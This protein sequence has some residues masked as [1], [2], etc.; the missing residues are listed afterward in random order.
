MAHQVTFRI[1]DRPVGQKDLVF[2]VRQNGEKFGRLK[3][4]KGCIV[5][6][7]GRKSKAFRLSW[8]QLDRLARA[9]GRRGRYPV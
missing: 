8:D 3:V 1:P 4:S 9:Q 6:L 2:S 5:W 7:P